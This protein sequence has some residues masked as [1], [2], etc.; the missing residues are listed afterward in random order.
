MDFDIIYKKHLPHGVMS[1]GTSI[2]FFG[3]LL[4]ADDRAHIVARVQDANRRFNHRAVLVIRIADNNNK[5][6]EVAPLLQKLR[7]TCKRQ[8]QLWLCFTFQD[9]ANHIRAILTDANNEDIQRK[10]KNRT[11]KARL[12][13]LYFIFYE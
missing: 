11:K 2:F 13:F 1:Q 12:E 6:P 8:Q 4:R 9:A 7:A 3:D 5:L 10:L